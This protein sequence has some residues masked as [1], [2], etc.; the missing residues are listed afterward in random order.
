[1]SFKEIANSGLI[2]TLVIISIILV[3]EQLVR[4]KHSDVERW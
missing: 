3:V 2:W 4:L 1:M